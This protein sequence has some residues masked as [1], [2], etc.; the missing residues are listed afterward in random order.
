MKFLI[1][2][3]HTDLWWRPNS[4]GY[5][6]N[7]AEAGLY[8]EG[9][10]RTIAGLRRDPCDL[11]VPLADKRDELL[12]IRDGAQRLLDELG[13]VAVAVLANTQE[14]EREIVRAIE[15]VAG[16]AIASTPGCSGT[17]RWTIQQCVIAVRRVF[18]ARRKA[19]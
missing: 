10:A 15:G 12:A 13:D 3:Q 19:A 4:C 11:P 1:Q 7:L 18:N 17:R 6:R 9:E 5:T 16:L 8:T 2:V 14:F